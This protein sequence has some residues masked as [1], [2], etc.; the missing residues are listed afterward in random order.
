MTLRSRHTQELYDLDMYESDNTKVES[1][2]GS[3]GDDANWRG[4]E[5]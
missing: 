2:E 5:R 3:G 1:I 4:D